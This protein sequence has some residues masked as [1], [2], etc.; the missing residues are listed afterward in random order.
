M[1][2]Q[3]WPPVVG[4]GHIVIVQAAFVM[5]LGQAAAAWTEPETFGHLGVQLDV[6][7]CCASKFSSRMS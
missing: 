7:L 4:F 2:L 3:L 6:A 1:L 5:F